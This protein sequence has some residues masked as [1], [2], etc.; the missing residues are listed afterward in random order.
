ML[1]VHSQV[2]FIFFIGLMQ[3]ITFLCFVDEFRVSVKGEN[4]GKK[5]FSQGFVES[6][7]HLKDDLVV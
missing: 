2:W 4:L 7:E 3:L 5:K 6:F 1:N